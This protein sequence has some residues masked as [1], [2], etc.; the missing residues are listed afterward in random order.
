MGISSID[1][2]ILCVWFCFDT[3]AAQILGTRTPAA[4][5]QHAH[6]RTPRARRRCARARL[7][8]CTAP[9]RAFCIL[10]FC[11]ST[12]TPTYRSLNRVCDQS[13]VWD[14]P[15][16]RAA[17]AHCARTAP[18]PRAAA[19]APRLPRTHADQIMIVSII[20]PPHTPAA[21]IVD[22]ADALLSS[23]SHRSPL[24]ACTYNSSYACPSLPSFLP[25]SH[26]PLTST[27]ITHLPSLPTSQHTL[28]T[29]S[30]TCNNLEREGGLNTCTHTGRW[31]G[32]RMPC[33]PSYLHHTRFISGGGGQVGGGNNII[34]LFHSNWHYYY[35]KL[36][37]SL[38]SI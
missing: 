20:V 36:F 35:S 6:T 3:H 1:I 25:V 10:L 33:Q 7:L 11:R 17:H 26:F 31:A 30:C 19:H 28:Y 4:H 18:P 34:P 38:F 9:R 16:R 24:P 37:H 14:A 22:G 5:A 29:C 32:W 23:L 13:Y 2:Q 27:Y 15:L 21:T 8:H 12:P